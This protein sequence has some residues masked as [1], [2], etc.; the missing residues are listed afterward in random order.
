MEEAPL[1]VGLVF[2]VSGS[3]K[4]QQTRESATG[5]AQFFRT[6]N[7]EDEFSDRLQ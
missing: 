6:S 5:C 1:S 7:P 4:Q 2:D 3:M